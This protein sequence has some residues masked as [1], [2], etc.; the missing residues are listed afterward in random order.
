MHLDHDPSLVMLQTLPAPSS[1]LC[2]CSGSL[3]QRRK[4]RCPQRT[5]NMNIL[6]ILW[7]NTKTL[8]FFRMVMTP[9]C[10]HW[11]R[12]PAL[13]TPCAGTIELWQV[14]QMPVTPLSMA[15]VEGM[16]I[17]LGP[18]GPVSAAACPAWSRAREQVLPEA[19]AQ[20]MS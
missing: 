2:L 8:K 20:M 15:A 6:S 11:M 9:A 17:V 4:A 7:R 5:M 16:R 13:P 12:A 18:V 14:A 1:T 10:F 19:E 3:M